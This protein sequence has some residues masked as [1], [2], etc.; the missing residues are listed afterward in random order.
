MEL[1]I[2]K[3][4]IVMLRSFRIAEKITTRSM[5][6]F[7]TSGKGCSSDFRRYVNFTG[8]CKMKLYGGIYTWQD[9]KAAK[10]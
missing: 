2:L 4:K 1:V 6:P 9:L 5:S 10:K 7:I 3:F 8:D